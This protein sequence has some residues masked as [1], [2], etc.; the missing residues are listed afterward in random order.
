MAAYSIAEL[1]GMPMEQ[2]IREHDAQAKN[3]VVGVNYYL[4]EIRRRQ[5]KD[6]GD[7]MDRMTRTIR[8]FTIWI[9]LCTVVSTLAILWDVLGPHHCG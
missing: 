9:F 6:Q 1:Q 2:L 4:D 5:A 3:T 8:T 7:Q